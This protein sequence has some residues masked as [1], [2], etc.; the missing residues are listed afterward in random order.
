LQRFARAIGFNNISIELLPGVSKSIG[1]EIE[2]IKEEK[3]EVSTA[4]VNDNAPIV[5]DVRTVQE[6]RTGAFP[7]ALNI[8]LDELMVRRTEIGSNLAREI[9][10]YCASGGRSAYAKGQL[11]QLGYKNVKNGGGISSM[12]ATLNKPVTTSNEPLIVDV[13][14][15]AEFA[16]GAFPGAINIQLDE[17]PRRVSELGD[18]SRNITLYCASGARSAYGQRVLQQLGFTNVKNGGG[19]MHMME[20]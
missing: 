13:R 17:L 3:K 10:V 16:G 4:K 1:S 7:G 18:K 19:L 12:M 6:F 2:E 5:I 14:T 20:R 15:P 8:P 9:V 11:Q